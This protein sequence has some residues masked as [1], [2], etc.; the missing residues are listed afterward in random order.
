MRNALFVLVGFTA[1]LCA[2]NA[3]A[4][5]PCGDDCECTACDC[6]QAAS[7]VQAREVRFPIA[8][9]VLRGAAR[10]VTAPVRFFHNRKPVRRFFSHV[11]PVRRALR[12]VFRRRCCC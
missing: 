7:V 5:C 8:R 4:D 3:N 11:Q 12:F 2:A 1:L 6:S 9:A 10:V